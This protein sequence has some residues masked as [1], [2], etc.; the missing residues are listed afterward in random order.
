MKSIIDATLATITIDRAQRRDSVPMV[1]ASISLIIPTTNGPNPSPT[2]FRTKNKMA[3]EIALNEAGTRLW[4]TAIDG[5]RYMLYK[6]E[7]PDKQI[8]E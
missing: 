8:K 2:R 1:G 4:A 5:P 3:D 6:K 7:H